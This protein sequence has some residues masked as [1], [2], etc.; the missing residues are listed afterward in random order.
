M[1]RFEGECSTPPVNLSASAV[2]EPEFST[3]STIAELVSQWKKNTQVTW[4][5]PANG[6]SRYVSNVKNTLQI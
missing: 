6:S 3:T 2:A 5:Y 4:P 1:I